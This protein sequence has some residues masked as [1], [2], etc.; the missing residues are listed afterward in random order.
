MK[1]TG[2]LNQPLSQ[3]IA[4][5]GHFDTLVVGDAGLPVPKGVA[6]I[7][8][9]LCAGTPAFTQVLQTILSELSLQS[10]VVASEMQGENPKVYQETMRLLGSTPVKQVSHERFKEMTANA[11]AVV[12]TG[13][14]T[15]YAN[16]ILESGVVF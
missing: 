9:A 4:G 16:I 1:K 3:I 11:V 5:M 15:P 8:L 6:K 13:E 7:D 2:V 10:A 14:F 12:R